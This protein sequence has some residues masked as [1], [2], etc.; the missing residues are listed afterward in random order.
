MKLGAALC[1]APR[2]FAATATSSVGRT[3][4]G[5]VGIRFIWR[6]CHCA[7]SWPLGSCKLRLL[8]RSTLKPDDLVLSINFLAD[9]LVTQREPNSLSCTVERGESVKL[10]F[11]GVPKISRLRAPLVARNNG[12]KVASLLDL[13]G[14][15]A[16]VVQMRAE[17]KDYIDL[18]AI[19]INGTVD[20][21]HA[22]S[23]ARGIYGEQFNPQAALKALAFFED[24]TLNEL[25][26]ATKQR[27]KAA[28]VAVDIRHLP[29]IEVMGSGYHHGA[30]S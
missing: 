5:S 30:R 25:P 8:Q 9:A 23:A 14:T 1:P 3:V 26:E 19:I 4:S 24:G 29:N 21:S 7:A 11:F 10:S 16:R 15:K 28:V 17:A 27:L 13:A 2:H 6:H 18:D 22:L 12:L 20:L